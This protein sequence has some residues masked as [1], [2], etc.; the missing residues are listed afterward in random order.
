MTDRGTTD[1]LRKPP[2]L[3]MRIGR[4][5]KFGAV[6]RMVHVSRLH[7]VCEEAR[8]PNR[9]ECFAKGTATFLIMGATCT[10]NCLFCSI[11]HGNAEHSLHLNTGNLFFLWTDGLNESRDHAG[12]EFGFDRVI[13]VGRRHASRG[14]THLIKEMVDAERRFRGE[15]PQSDDLT[16]LAVQVKTSKPSADDVVEVSRT[17]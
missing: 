6:K 15:S 16:L 11:N 13:D 8:C 12:N 1:V 3:K 5:R 9:C 17:E 10:R 2:W 7:T 14:A 4:G